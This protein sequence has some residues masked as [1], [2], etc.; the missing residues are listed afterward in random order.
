MH[1]EIMDHIFKCTRKD[2]T[3]YI[4]KFKL[5]DIIGEIKSTVIV[6]NNI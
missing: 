5:L 4:Q 6:G 3:V 1:D 2:I